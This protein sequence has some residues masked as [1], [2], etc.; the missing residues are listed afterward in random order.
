LS[1]LRHGRKVA[2]ASQRIRTG[3]VLG[4]LGLVLATFSGTFWIRARQMVRDRTL[5]AFPLDT[6]YREYSRR[7]VS[8]PESLYIRMIQARMNPDA[9]ALAWIVAPFHLDFQRNRFLTAS[10]PGLINPAL[11]LPAGVAPAVLEDYLRRWGVRYVLVEVAGPG[12]KDLAFLE[13]QLASR[14]PV[15]RKIGDYAIYFRKSLEVLA[16][17]GRILHSDGRM[18]LFE[19]RAVSAP[20]EGEPGQETPTNSTTRGPIH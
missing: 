15:Y 11:H 19:L 9:T 8:Q 17:R 6:P 5:L 2:P 18:L 13:T 16:R 12:I 20:P 7:M 14:R 10:E 3:L 4:L 1:Y